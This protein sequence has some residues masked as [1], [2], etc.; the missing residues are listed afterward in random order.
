M[1][2]GVAQD[3]T[4]LIIFRG[5]QGLGGGTLMSLNFA[6]ISTVFPPAQRAKYQ[7]LF[8]GVFGVSSVMGPL[9]GGVLTDNFNWRWIF[10]VNIPVGLLALA[11]LYFGLHE[12]HIRRAPKPID[13]AGAALIVLALVPLLLALSM[14]GRDFAWTSPVILGMLA[15]S[16][17]SLGAFIWREGRAPDPI[18]SLPLFKNKV[19]SISM[20][21]IMIMT[22]GMFGTAIFI[23]LF[24]QGV[25]GASAT[26]SGSV[27]APM[28]LS[29]IATSM[30][31]GQLIARF[32]RYKPFAVIGVGVFSLGLFLMSGMGPDTD[33]QTVLRNMIILGLGM[34]PTMPVFMLATQS[35][36]RLDQIGVATSVQQF[37]RSI[38]GLMG[39]AIFGSVLAA[40]F[41]PGVQAAL[42]EDAAAALPPGALQ[43]LN[44][45]QA[46]FNADTALNLRQ[47]IAAVLPPNATFL[48]DEIFVAIRHGLAE[49]IHE[50]YFLA[51]CIVLCGWVLAWLLPEVPLMDR[52]AGPRPHG[53]TTP[54]SPSAP[55]A[56]EPQ[57]EVAGVRGTALQT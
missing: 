2:C 25:I 39:T 5:L 19:I 26:Q 10:Y 32:K 52:S 21:C 35:S 27:M 48:L 40:R 45:P 42:P 9:I 55:T 12:R 6:L 33:Y 17:L 56:A 3:M 15:F 24:I 22:C 43:A 31:T 1:L 50:V 20:L 41:L 18:I 4:Q 54:A 13:Y 23:P 11:V 53:G 44:N 34:G 14:G 29:M 47:T 36:V 57:R 30:V 37:S 38:G 51:F 49:A 16:A 7:G 8:S 28:M 46:L